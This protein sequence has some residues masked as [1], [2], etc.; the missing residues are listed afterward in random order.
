MTDNTLPEVGSRWTIDGAPAEV[1]KVKKR[2][3]GWQVAVFG[4]RAVG[5]LEESYTLRLADFRK[6]AKPAGGEHGNPG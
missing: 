3:R 6:Q 2:G 4:L 1:T 5:H